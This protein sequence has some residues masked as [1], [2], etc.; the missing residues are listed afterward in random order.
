MMLNYCRTFIN[1]DFDLFLKVFRRHIKGRGRGE[2]QTG[3][4]WGYE[5]AAGVEG[6]GVYRRGC[7]K[8]GN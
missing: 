7:H 8:G 2:Q 5:L 1:V 3:Y 4:W 6:T